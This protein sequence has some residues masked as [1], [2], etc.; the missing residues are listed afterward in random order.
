[1]HRRRTDEEEVLKQLR[2]ARERDSSYRS[3]RVL[4][5][6][7]THPLPVAAEA[8]RLFMGTNLGDPGLF[9]G[10]AEVESKVVAEL[11]RLLNLEGGA[12]YVTTGGTE[13]N[14]QAL[15]AIRNVSDVEDP[16]IVV[17]RS[18]HFSFDKAADMLGVRLRRA[19]LGG[20]YAVDPS[21]AEDLVNDRTVALVAVAG[22]TETGQVDPVDE[23]AEVAEEHCLLLHVDA[24]FGGFVLPFLDD[25]PEFDFSIDAVDT[26]TVD[27]HKMGFSTIP[28]G[29]LLLREEELLDSLATA[30]PYLT[31]DE[32]HSLTGTRTGAGAASAYAAMTRL[33]REGY[34]EEVERCM[35]N[36]ETLARGVGEVPGLG[37][38]LEPVTN[39]VSVTADEPHRLAAKLEERG[40]SVSVSSLPEALRLVVMPHVTRETVEQFLDDLE[41]LA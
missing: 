3:D 6:M 32:Q 24:A 41:D 10:A 27:P 30:T 5:S 17:P 12:G 36:A 26:M 29:S 33:G 18:A 9:P 19:P 14:V 38:S 7:C 40:W 21:G 22:T 25:A 39:V 4:S 2:K 37:L 11:S 20:D 13:S 31:S 8:H 15:R 34:R 35:G 1:M 23:L 28:S 16:E